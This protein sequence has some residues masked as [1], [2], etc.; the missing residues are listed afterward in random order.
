MEPAQR[1]TNAAIL[2][3]AFA[4]SFAVPLPPASAGPLLR[5]LNVGVAVSPN[6]KKVPQ[7]KEVFERR[8]A[9][10]S[11]IFET[12]FKVKFKVRTYWN[13][14]LS[15]E[16]VAPSVMLED[17]R[18]RYELR[19]VDIVIGLTHLRTGSKTPVKDLHT[20]GQARPFSGYLVLRYPVN[21]LYKIQEETV[22][23]HELGHLFGA[24]HSADPESIMAPVVNLQ[25]PVRFD[26]ENRDILQLTRDINFARGIESVSPAL[27]RQL[28]AAY[29]KMIRT[30]ESG[31]F[32]H[33]LGLFYLKMGEPGKTLKAWTKARQ[34]QPDYY[35]IRYNLGYLAYQMGDYDR[36]TRELGAAIA[37]LTLPSQK[38]EK[39]RVLD[40]LAGSYFKKENYLSAH[41]TW[42]QALA[43]DPSNSQIKLNL[44]VL[45]LMMGQEGA[46]IQD[47]E[48]F[49]KKDP[50]NPRILTYIGSAYYRKELY[51][52]S[53]EY[54]EKALTV[55]KS[56][57]K[58]DQEKMPNVNQMYEIQNNLAAAYMKLEK[59]ELGL[60][61]LRKACEMRPSLE[62]H[63]QLGDMYY[64]MGR[65]DDAI[66]QLVKVLE[67]RKDDHT[68]Y[69]KVGVA[70]VQKGDN[71]NAVPLFREGLRYTNDRMV[72]STFHRNI[73]FA[74]VQLEQWDLALQDFQIALNMNWNDPES[75]FGAG[76]ARMRKA[77]LLGAAE[78]FRNA[79]TIN[80]KHAQ[81]QKLL[82]AVQENMKKASEMGSST[83]RFMP[84]EEAR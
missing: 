80:P 81:A 44:A 18:A 82:Q 15:D 59:P 49:L 70:F 72:Q 12:E 17:L 14:N 65:W 71:R 63:E 48:R 64:K 37:M 79:L 29:L 40:A 58:I 19:D 62:C 83:V 73:G 61:Y 27:S 51:D 66:E 84:A 76:I 47:F 25:V 6:F 28:A 5:E 23:A 36:A 38:K 52:K 35:V 26:P 57:K 69:A 78:A 7:W 3:A 74:L 33:S 21:S 9:Y 56:R 22:L 45:K 1:K 20:I 75:H 67:N 11:R 50:E 46:A 41:R 30:A 54:L 31:D 8:L 34:L 4:L 60:N 55:M 39:A 16:N 43:L 53:I 42:N 24:I 13:W 32:Y 68:L 2:L 77:D 10:A